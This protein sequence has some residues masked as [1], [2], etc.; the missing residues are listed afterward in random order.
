M[1]VYNIASCDLSKGKISPIMSRFGAII[2]QALAPILYS[3]HNDYTL[4]LGIIIT[5]MYKNE[6]LPSQLLRS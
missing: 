4:S 1:N 2:N 5:I 6:F 3:F